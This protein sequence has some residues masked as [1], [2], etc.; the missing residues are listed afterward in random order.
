MR[1]LAPVVVLI[2]ALPLAPGVPADFLPATPMPSKPL[3]TDAVI[4]RI[5][6]GS[7]YRPARPDTIFRTIREARPDLFLFIGD[8]VYPESEH[9]DPALSSLKQA[10]ALLAQSSA[11]SAL[12][13]EIPVITTW[14]DHDYGLDDAGRSFRHRET[15]ESLF[16]HVWA[17]GPDDPRR[18]REGVYHEVI[19]GPAGRQLQMILLDTRF[20]RSD[21]D[22]TEPTMLG[23]T[24]WQWLTDMLEKPADLRLLV[25]PVIVFGPG[26][27]EAWTRMPGELRR[28]TA[29]LHRTGNIFM[30]SG[31]LHSA[32]FYHKVDSDR[33][34]VEIVA[35]S[36]N[37]PLSG[38]LS[39]VTDRPEAAR[40]G[41]PFHDANF[42]LIDIDWQIGNILLTVRDQAG[43]VVRELTVAMPRH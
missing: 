1:L 42:A 12:R 25:S 20:F 43:R 39:Q 15:A 28:L 16:E 41:V 27:S 14:D 19:T 33:E 9:D 32:A 36:L 24:Q 31:D 5:A 29:L 10:Y 40:L 30:V 6:A 7:C 3:N 8:N 2:L 18:Q 26:Y 21:Y 22:S 38:I 11:F 34:V 35:S 23:E 4:T 17:L 37:D 13:A